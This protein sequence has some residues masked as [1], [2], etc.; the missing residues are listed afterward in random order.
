VGE[1]LVGPES[2]VASI[3]RYGSTRMPLT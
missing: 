3:A 2:P 1:Y